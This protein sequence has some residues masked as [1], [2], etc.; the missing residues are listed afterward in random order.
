MSE[1]LSIALTAE[2]L[3]EGTPEEKACFGLLRM[4][5]R[6]SDLISGF[7]HYTNGYRPGPLVSG[8]ALGEWLAWNW[9]R[10]QWEPRTSS[11]EWWRA[12]NLT[13]IGEGYG[14]PNLTVFSDGVRAA[15]VCKASLRADAKPFRYLG[16]PACIVSRT[17]L[18]SAID[19]YQ[20][21][22]LGRLRDGG[23]AASNLLTLWS[24]VLAERADPETAKRRKLEALLGRDPDAFAVDDLETL[25]RDEAL[26]GESAVEELAADNRPA[27]RLFTADA[28]TGFAQDFGQDTRPDD[29]ARLRD[30]A[31]LAFRADVPAWVIGSRAALRLRV[32]EKL[33]DGRIN[34]AALARM[35]GVAE[36]AIAGAEKS[37]AG[38]LSFSLDRSPTAGRVVFRSRWKSSRRFDAARLIG[39]RA[40]VGGP[41][42]LRAATRAGT[43]RQKMQRAFAAEFLSPFEAVEAFLSGDFS[44]DA[45][46]EAARHFDVSER[47]ILTLLVNHGRVEREELDGELAP[48]A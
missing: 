11:A 19:D 35:A 36:Q 12:H 8:Y 26:L 47:T 43:Y 22:L 10:L 32:Q 6:G 20:G 17:Q 46:E 14:W 4:Q 40:V 38:P 34:D 15:L 2:R 37:E 31:D 29:A 21:Q 24:D 45:Q 7:D 5:S 48:A 28:L 13:A 3:D 23:I 27:N 39:D 9:W 33:G 42:R 25:V 44:P 30:K 1:D 41:D 16:S 18:Q